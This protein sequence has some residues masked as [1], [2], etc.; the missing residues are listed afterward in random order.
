MTTG[1][2]RLRDQVLALVS[3]IADGRSID[4]TASW[5]AAGLDSLDLLNL[6]TGLEERFDLAISDSAW[7]AL[8]NVNDVVDFLSRDTL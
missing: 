7:L 6:I 3:L 5:R 4:D 2:G 8:H 1:T